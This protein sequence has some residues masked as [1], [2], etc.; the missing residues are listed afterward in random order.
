MA[1]AS[2]SPIFKSQSVTLSFEDDARYH[3]SISNEKKGGSKFQS[4]G[5]TFIL[6]IFKLLPKPMKLIVPWFLMENIF[7]YNSLLNAYAGKHTGTTKYTINGKGVWRGN[8]IV[9]MILFS[10]Y[11][12]YVYF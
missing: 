12:Y 8:N 6:N 10:K 2:F 9:F 3:G 11:F 4:L 5:E 7:G 1:E